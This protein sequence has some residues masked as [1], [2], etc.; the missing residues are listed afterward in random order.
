ML[1]I[2]EKRLDV[3]VCIIFC[4]IVG[5]CW[6]ELLS[7]RNNVDSFAIISLGIQ[8]HVLELASLPTRLIHILSIWSDERSSSLFVCFLKFK[9]YRV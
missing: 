3:A 9:T 4:W 5:Q 8:R 2:I 1:E 6:W 7:M